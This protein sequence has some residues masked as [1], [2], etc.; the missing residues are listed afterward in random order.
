MP[1]STIFEDTNIKKQ[2]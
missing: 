1:A 2:G